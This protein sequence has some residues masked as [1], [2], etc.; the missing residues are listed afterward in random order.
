[1]AQLKLTGLRIF[2][3]EDPVDH[4]RLHLHMEWDLRVLLRI[5]Y[6][7]KTPCTSGM[8][9]LQ[10]HQWHRFLLRTQ[11]P[12]GELL[13]FSSSSPLFIITF[14]LKK[15]CHNN[16]YISCNKFRCICIN[17]TKVIEKNKEKGMHLSWKEKGERNEYTE[18]IPEEALPNLV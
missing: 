11:L 16:H 12:A 18:E 4:H 2:N 15:V 10:V 7:L 6:H 5:L 1:M 14:F 3:P 8:N 17:D 9:T 13:S